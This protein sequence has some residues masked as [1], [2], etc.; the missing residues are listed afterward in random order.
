MGSG[1]NTYFA[2]AEKEEAILDTKELLKKC[3][4][5]MTEQQ[6]SLRVK[7]VLEQITG[8]FIIHYNLQEK[9]RKK[10]HLKGTYQTKR[11]VCCFI[12]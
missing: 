6:P 3:L 12:I 11:Q 1:Y 2:K 7:E 9:S 4:I 5:S 10:I 8:P